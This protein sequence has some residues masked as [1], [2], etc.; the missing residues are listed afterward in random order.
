MEPGIS[1]QQLM[2]QLEVPA[3]VRPGE[4]FRA[5]LGGD[6]MSVTCPDGAR[7]GSMIQ[8]SAPPVAIATVTGT[9]VQEGAALCSDVTV[10]TGAAAAYPGATAAYL[11]VAMHAEAVPIMPAAAAAAM[12]P[13]HLVEVDEI[14]PA[15]WMCLILG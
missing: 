5:S 13:V 6:W 15:G 8:V 2:Y 11:G 9:P 14:S 12:A 10:S 1:S 3:G 7:P 4:R